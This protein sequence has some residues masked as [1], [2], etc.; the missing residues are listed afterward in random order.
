VALLPFIE[1]NTSKQTFK[2]LQKTYRNR[3]VT[4]TGGASF[5]GSHLA[6]CLLDLGS[7]VRVIDDL[8]SGR[9]EHLTMSN[10][11]DFFKFDLRNSEGLSP[12]LKGSDYLFHLA[13]IHGGRGFIETH[14]SLMLPNVTIDNNVFSAAIDCEVKVLIHASSACAYPINLQESETELNFLSEEMGSMQRAETSFPD[15]VY[16]WT[17][18]FGEFQLEHYVFGTS[19]RGRSARIFTAYGERENESHAAI[20][21]IAKALLKADPFPVWGTGQQTRNFTYVSDTVTGLLLLGCDERDLNFDVFNIG[22]TNH[23]KVLDFIDEI[24]TQVGWKPKKLDLQVNRPTGVSSRASNNGKIDAI[25]GWSPNV[26]VKQGLS[27][28]IEWYKNSSLLPDSLN[29]L[30]ERLMAR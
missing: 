26:S 14:K 17:K 29:A 2:L 16:G 3:V 22:T 27:R 9:L 30:E 7:K 28:T 19:T 8:S 6:D 1:K 24:F 25:F 13:A 11:L 12:I 5:I 10:S 23:I 15:G 21:L 18:L 4:I 20:A